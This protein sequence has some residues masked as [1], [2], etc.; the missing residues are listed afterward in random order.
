M[1]SLASHIRDINHNRARQFSLN[2]EAPLL[3][4]RPDRPSRNGSNIDRKGSAR[5]GKGYR[6]AYARSCTIGVSAKRRPISDVADTCV[7]KR[8]RL[9]H[10][11]YQWRAGFER[12]GVGFVTRAVLKK[13][14]VAA[15]DRC[16]TIA[17]RVP[18]ESNPRRWVE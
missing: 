18:G 2:S 17:P 3:R 7:T 5:L 11:K 8:K 15:T 1:C 6:R 13:N 12:A 10:T 16:L 4:V 9:R 14:A